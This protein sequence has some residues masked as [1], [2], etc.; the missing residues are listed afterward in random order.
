MRRVSFLMCRPSFYGVDYEINPWMHIRRQPNRRLAL[1]QWSTLRRVLEE[2]IR[3]RVHVV[4]ARRGL[5]DMCFTANA[6]L[7]H[8]RIF[9]PSRF[10][11]KERASEEPYFTAWFRAHGY[12]I[13]SLP[14]DL[15]FEG[16]GDALFVGNTLIAGY[17]FRSDFR[18]HEAIAQVLNVRVCSVAL[19]NEYF[20]HLDTCFSPLGPDS[21]IYYPRAFDV[22]GRRLLNETIGDLV[23]VSDEEAYQFGCNSVVVGKQAIVPKPCVNL[24]RDLTRRGYTV[25]SLDLSEFKKA[26]G[27]ARCLTLSLA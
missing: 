12:H 21:A 13:V 3:G 22:Y 5:P 20:Y 10:R 11:Y 16:A 23:R 18:T 1:A 8:K 24:R 27:S 14:D 19:V 2:E 26:G 7:V 6:G 15:R 4:R 25:Y 9:I 17:Y